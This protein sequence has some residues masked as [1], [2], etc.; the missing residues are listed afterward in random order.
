MH[1]IN[2]H[3]TV[4]WLWLPQVDCAGDTAGGQHGPGRV[5]LDAV[6]NGVVSVKH[7]HNVSRGLLPDKDVP[8]VAPG[9]HVLSLLP[10]KVGLLDVRVGIG[11]AG[12]P[13]RV[14]KGSVL[15]G[16]LPLGELDVASLSPVAVAE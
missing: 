6:H 11:V 15:F 10:E 13:V 4:N 16:V 8:V 7:S 3:L 14:V 1:A 5:P 2:A 9:C 12:E